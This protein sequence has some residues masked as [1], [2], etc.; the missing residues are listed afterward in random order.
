MSQLLRGWLKDA[1]SWNIQT[2]AANLANQ[3]I[4][5]EEEEFTGVNAEALCYHVKKKL[6]ALKKSMK[7]ENILGRY[8][9][10]QRNHNP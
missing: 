5:I 7:A 8:W 4:L 1:A 6:T 2:E 9:E 10:A 3:Q